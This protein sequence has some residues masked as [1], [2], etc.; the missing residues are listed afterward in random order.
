MLGKALWG[1]IER[2]GEVANVALFP[3][4]QENSS[5]T[6]IDVVDGGMRI[7]D[8]ALIRPP[9]AWFATRPSRTSANQPHPDCRS[10]RKDW[11]A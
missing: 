1:G 8:T 5:V 4:S 3:A 10:H 9:N 6:G 11:T 2:A 7:W